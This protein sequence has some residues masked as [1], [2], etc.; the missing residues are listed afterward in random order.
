MIEEGDTS[1]VFTAKLTK[2]SHQLS[3]VFKTADGKEVGAY[4]LIVTP[5]E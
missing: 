2:G 3:P 5:V 1:A 4:Y